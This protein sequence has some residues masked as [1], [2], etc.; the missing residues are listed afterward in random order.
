[1]ARDAR[2]RRTGFRTIDE[3]GDKLLQSIRAAVAVIA[4]AVIEAVFSRRNTAL[5]A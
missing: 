3:E 4:V 2:V 5:H 1:L